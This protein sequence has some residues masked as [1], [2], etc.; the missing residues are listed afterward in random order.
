MF[1]YFLLL[2][3]LPTVTH[4]FAQETPVRVS[5]F[6][7]GLIGESSITGVQSVSGTLY[8][9]FRTFYGNDGAGLISRLDPETGAP[10]PILDPDITEWQGGLTAN[11]IPNV[12]NVGDKTFAVQ[13]DLASGGNLYSIEG[14]EA[15]LLLSKPNLTFSE[16]V[17]FNDSIYFVV[18]GLPLSQRP[19][20]FDSEV[21]ELWRTD[22]TPEGTQFVASMLTFFR[23]S[24]THLV[25]GENS[26]MISIIDNSEQV[27]YI[28]DAPSSELG[29]LGEGFSQFILDQGFFRTS[30]NPIGY[31]DGAFYAY[32]RRDDNPD[33]Q[34][35]RIDEET[36]VITP[37]NLPTVPDP[38]FIFELYDQIDFV[39]FQ[40]SLYV[41]AGRTDTG[42]GVDLYR[43]QGDNGL[44]LEG[45]LVN[46]QTMGTTLALDEY[47]SVIEG[48][49][50][51]FLN[52]RPETDLAL[53]AFSSGMEA[54]EVRAILDGPAETGNGG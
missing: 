10:T 5:D 22:G 29:I 36:F 48:D 27:F 52:R 54:P 6:N 33:N 40:D 39:S 41:F 11:N 47:L 14:D 26:L 50:L 37:I 28:Y 53:Y 42:N 19:N 45:L 1:R 3:I 49:T 38:F 21:A 15:T 31:F 30:F 44:E 17:A 7:F 43:V 13:R 4:L 8:G 12:F 51:F 9:S 32:G 18:G 35:F 34:I 46:N 20:Q 23:E 24:G 2:A 16:M 25:A